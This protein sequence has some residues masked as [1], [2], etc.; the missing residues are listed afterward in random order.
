M[1]GNEMF[2]YPGMKHFAYVLYVGFGVPRNLCDKQNVL[3][4]GTPR[5]VGFGVQRNL[6]DKQNVLFYGTPRF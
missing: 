4:Y 1:T 6:C 2:L 3:F 5:Y